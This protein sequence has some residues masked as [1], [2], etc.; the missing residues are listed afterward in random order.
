MCNPAEEADDTEQQGA[1]SS[2]RER[3]VTEKGKEMKE[4]EAKKND[5]SLCKF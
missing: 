4:Y 1:R 3:H 5:M 2:Y